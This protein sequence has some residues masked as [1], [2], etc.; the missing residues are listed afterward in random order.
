MEPALPRGTTVHG[1]VRESRAVGLGF[2]RERAR[3]ALGFTD[4]RTPGGDSIPCSLE[5][6]AVDNAREAVKRDNV[7]YGVLAAS[8][9]HGWFNGVWFRPGT[10]FVRRAAFGLTGT[11]GAVQSRLIP[12]PLGAGIVM[13][14]KAAVLR[15]PDP[16]IWLPAG[17]DLIV[18]VAGRKVGAAR[19]AAPDMAISH[20]ALALAQASAAIRRPNGEAVVDVVNLAFSGSPEEI[21]AAFESAGWLP[22]DPHSGKAVARAYNAY[23]SMKTY[24]TAPVSPL[25]YDDRL[26]DAVFQ[27]SFNSVSKRHHIRIWR[28]SSSSSEA[29]PPFWLGAA[30]H[31]IGIALNWS[32]MKIT[33][34]IDPEIDGERTK[35]LNDLLETGCVAGVRRVPRKNLANSDRSTGTAVTDGS[36]WV[37][38]LRACSGLA[39]PRMPTGDR[40]LGRMA[41]AV[42]RTVLETRYYFTRGNAFYWAGLGVQKGVRKASKAVL[43]SRAV[44]P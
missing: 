19:E 25:Y 1:V 44:H 31:D 2:R 21:K 26:P 17:T 43:G 35:V 16:E 23:A 10:S 15:M 37:V 30:T 6:V 3:L 39:S 14:S 8:H 7:I 42:R 22:A 41:T 13:A 29:D 33:H 18:R 38:D 36:L 40:K 27:K 12:N 28:S 34:E 20:Q 24:D 32:G 4:C 5:L 9:P 11:A